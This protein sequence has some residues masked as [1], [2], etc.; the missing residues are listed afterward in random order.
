MS[1]LGTL[2]VGP[3]VTC[4]LNSIRNLSLKGNVAS[5]Q[6][7]ACSNIFTEKNHDKICINGAGISTLIAKLKMTQDPSDQRYILETFANLSKNERMRG[8]L[9][10]QELED[11]L[12]PFLASTNEPLLH[13]TQTILGNL[14]T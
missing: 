10:K 12:I 6:F 14:S 13:A 5:I 2:N 7:P 9:S 3:R 11:L 8:F 1:I 4:I